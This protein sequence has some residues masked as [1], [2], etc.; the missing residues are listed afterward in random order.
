MK[1]EY[2]GSNVSAAM[3]QPLTERCTTKFETF[4]PVAPARSLTTIIHRANTAIFPATLF[5]P[6]NI[7]SREIQARENGHHPLQYSFTF[8]LL[9]LTTIPRFSNKSPTCVWNLL[10]HIL[11]DKGILPPSMQNTFFIH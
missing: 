1:G 4:R 10:P 2:V 6:P 3:S 7:Y 11:P 5:T 8:L 9:E